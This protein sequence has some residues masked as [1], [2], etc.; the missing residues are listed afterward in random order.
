MKKRFLAMLL[1]ATLTF[2]NSVAVFAEELENNIAEENLIVEE[3]EEE[4]EELTEESEEEIEEEKE[5]VALTSGYDETA[6]VVTNISISTNTAVPGDVVYFDVTVTE[7]ESGLQ[8]LYLEIGGRFYYAS[9]DA[10]CG[11]GT[12]TVAFTVPSDMPDWTYYVDDV[13]AKDMAGNFV[14]NGDFRLDDISV[15]VENSEFD[16]APII[17]DTYPTYYELEA[18]GTQI[19]NLECHDSDL[20]YVRVDCGYIDNGG[21]ARY[22]KKVDYYVSEIAENGM[23]QIEVPFTENLITGNFNY[24]LHV[25]DSNGNNRYGAG[26]SATAFYVTVSEENEEEHDLT[27]PVVTSITTNNHDITIPGIGYVTISGTED[28]SD[29]VKGYVSI[30]NPNSDDIVYANFETS[31]NED[32]TW[33]ATASFTIN[34][35]AK[36]GTYKTLTT[37]VYDGYGNTSDIEALECTW[38]VSYQYSSVS[39]D[40]TLSDPELINKINNMVDTGIAYIRATSSTVPAALFTAIDNTNKTVVIDNDGITWIFNGTDIITENI[41]DIDLSLNIANANQLTEY[42]Y[43]NDAEGVILHFASNGFLPGKVKIRIKSDYIS[44]KYDLNSQLYLAVIKNTVEEE[45]EFTYYEYEWPTDEDGNPIYYTVDYEYD[46]DGNIIYDTIL[47]YDFDGNPIYFEALD[48][49]GN[50][51]LD[52]DG[53]II[54][55]NEQAYYFV[56]RANYTYIEPEIIEKIEKYNVWV[57]RLVQIEDCGITLD[58]NGYVEL[59]MTHNS[60]YVLSANLPVANNVEEEH[61]QIIIVD[62][63]SI[64]APVISSSLSKPAVNNTSA[65]IEEVNDSVNNTSVIA[66]T[67]TTGIS[68]IISDALELALNNEEVSVKSNNDKLEVAISNET[69]TEVSDYEENNGFKIASSLYIPNQDTLETVSEFITNDNIVEE[70]PVVNVSIGTKIA[71]TFVN[72]RNNISATVTFIINFFINLFNL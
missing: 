24:Q 14:H 38:N 4:I 13:V 33:T 26:Y 71:N 2:S 57:D 37:H 47:M 32:H 11:S 7:E 61:K 64:I 30:V 72:I 46:E 8:S 41:K 59:T 69:N 66:S 5:L 45:R 58:S 6:P 15:Y 55:T 16:D 56:P 31:V 21:A 12:Y 9:V 60:S 50:V 3:S 28:T 19:I 36:A 44:A 62:K 1:V 65:V 27:A 18:P 35:T 34:K 52:E 23:Y 40:S 68:N 43:D 67:P 63:P 48:E 29:I 42:G 49:E 70:T 54:Y 51:I 53:N 20:A 22:D 17:T 39:F 25:E 10:S